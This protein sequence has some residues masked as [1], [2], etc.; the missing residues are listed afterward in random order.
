[1]AGRAARE[2]AWLEEGGQRPRSRAQPG[3]RA[4]SPANS[5]ARREAR[6]RLQHIRRRRRDLLEDTALGLVLA[7]V[8]LIVTAGLGVIALISVPAGLALIGSLFAEREIRKR[9]AARQGVTSTARSRGGAG[10]GGSS[11]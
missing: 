10:G 3:R 9:R 7:I 8:V 5:P 4:S 2:V 6:R 11:R 1:V